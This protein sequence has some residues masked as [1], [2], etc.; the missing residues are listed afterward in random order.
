MRDTPLSL[1]LF[2]SLI[3]GQ[4]NDLANLG[5]AQT[6]AEQGNPI[7][8]AVFE[9]FLPLQQRRKRLGA[10]IDPEKIFSIKSDAA[11]GRE[12]FLGK[13]VGQCANCHRLSGSGQSVGPDLDLVAKKKTRGQLLESILDPS[14]EI[15]PKF[16]S[17]VVLI[18][19]GTIV[20]GLKMSDSEQEIVVRQADGKDVPIAKETI[21]SFKLQP[22][23]LMPTGL[24]AEMTA[25]ELAD[26]VEFLWS[27]K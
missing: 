14:K 16:R 25:Q 26:L 2:A 27:L 23:S 9:R 13:R 3:S 11:R 21:E 7:T 6:A 1:E 24:A 10:N 20:T 5:V 19:D 4:Q 18:D 17:H 15:E 8:A 22:Q 12:L